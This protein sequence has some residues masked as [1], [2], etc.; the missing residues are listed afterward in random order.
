MP[1]CAWSPGT[2]PFLELLE[3]P[4]ELAYVGTPFEHFIR[5]NAE[6]GEYGPG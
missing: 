5:H 4:D 6:R 2:A 3:F 1:I